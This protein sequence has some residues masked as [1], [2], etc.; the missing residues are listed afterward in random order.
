MD[1][2]TVN[3]PVGGSR[4]LGTTTEGGWD[5]EQIERKEP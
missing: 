2:R 3:P 4:K 1:G 5:E